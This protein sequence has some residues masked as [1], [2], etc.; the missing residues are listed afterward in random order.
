MSYTLQIVFDPK[1]NFPI[2]LPCKITDRKGGPKVGT[3]V[4]YDTQTGEGLAVFEGDGDLR[5]E[6]SP[7][8]RISDYGYVA[9]GTNQ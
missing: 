8:I 9:K 4:S 6:Q 2:E 5:P 3:L 7:I 1:P